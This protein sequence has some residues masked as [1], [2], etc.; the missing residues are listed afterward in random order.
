VS[1]EKK[2]AN[3]K[4]TDRKQKALRE[5]HSTIATLRAKEAPVD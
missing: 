3:Q 1:H 5:K 4:E 2:T